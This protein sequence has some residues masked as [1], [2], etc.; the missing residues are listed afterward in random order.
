M[1]AAEGDEV[2]DAGAVAALDVGA[3]ELAALGEAEGVDGGGGGEDRVGGE[4]G[5]DLFDLEV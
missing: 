2:G 5:A 1:L 3:E 4:I